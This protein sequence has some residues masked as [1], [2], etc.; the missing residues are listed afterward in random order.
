VLSGSSLNQL[1]KLNG[2]FG[3]PTHHLGKRPGSEE[4]AIVLIPGKV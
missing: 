2:R 3:I 4:Y 1:K